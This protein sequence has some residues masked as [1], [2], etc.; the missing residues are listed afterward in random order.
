MSILSQNTNVLSS[1]FA[2]AEQGLA[3]AKSFTSQFIPVFWDVNTGHSEVVTYQLC[4]T[5]TCPSVLDS[6]KEFIHP[7]LFYPL[8]SST[9]V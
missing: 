8:K 6:F 7:G 1:C 4:T 3:A 5:L 9:G 2:R